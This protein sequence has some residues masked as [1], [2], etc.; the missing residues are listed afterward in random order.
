MPAQHRSETI[1]TSFE[2]GGKILVKDEM[3]FGEA[4]PPEGKKL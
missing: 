4:L 3:M 1:S 2:G